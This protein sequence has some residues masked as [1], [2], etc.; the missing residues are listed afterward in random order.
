MKQI[1][2]PDLDRHAPPSQPF[3]WKTVVSIGA[4][5]FGVGVG[6]KT[7]I[8]EVKKDVAGLEKTTARIELNSVTKSGVADVVRDELRQA[9][10]DADAAVQRAKR[11]P[12]VDRTPVFSPP[13]GP[14][15]GV[16][17]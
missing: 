8:A 12:D 17:P 9:Q 5:V 1:D 6:I 13:R 11:Q 14:R 16:T 15:P 4:I 2:P 10:S 3:D 7:D